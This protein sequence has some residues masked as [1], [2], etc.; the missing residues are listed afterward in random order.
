MKNGRKK[1]IVYGLGKAYENQKSLIENEFDVVGYSDKQKRDHDSY[2][3]P[4]EIG[5]KDFDY[6]YVTSKKNFREIKSE[7]LETVQNREDIIISA[8]DVWGAFENEEIRTNW[9]KRKLAKLPAGITLLDAGA[10][11]MQY[12]PYCERFHYIAQDFG[13]YVPDKMNKGLTPDKW[14]TTRVAITC[15]I[16]DMPLEDGSVDVVLCTEVL[17][18]LKDPIL[19]LK[20]FARI[21]KSGGKMLL[22]APFCS[23]THMAP[24]YFSNGFSEFWYLENLKDYGFTVEEIVPYGNYFAWIGQELYRVNEMVKN[25]CD[26][27]L[28]REETAALS[29]SIKLMSKLSGYNNGSEDV[30]CFG[31]MV[32]AY[33]G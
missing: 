18:H 28:S 24:Y 9:I 33:K 20:E 1:V 15:D 23:L 19:A 16:I 17:E 30:L 25:Y 29:E 5:K 21:I 3:A 32:S 7:L 26:L 6:I 10:G 12:A 27:E 13:K 22:T 11:E 31:Y 2:V 14:D 4:E 8:N